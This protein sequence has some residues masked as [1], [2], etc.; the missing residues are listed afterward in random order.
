MKFVK[1]ISLFL[2]Y[3]AIMLVIGMYTGIVLDRFFYPGREVKEG[4]I[5]SAENTATPEVS[6]SPWHTSAL[7]DEETLENTVLV[8]DGEF[9]TDNVVVV[10]AAD[11]ILTADTEYII[12]EYDTRRDTLI[13]NSVSVPVKYLGMNREEFVAAM[14][15]YAISPPL[16]EQERGFVGLEVRSFSASRVVVRM[17]Y[18]YVEPTQSFFIKVEDNKIVVYC[19]DEETLYMYTNIEA[20]SLP[21]YIQTQVSVGM[22]VEDEES[23]Y[24]FLESYSS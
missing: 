11:E 15:L 12:E 1:G 19:D 5:Q 13:E 18:A 6:A 10:A 9:M 2:L 17:H 7:A 14:E 16:S 23:L 22:F 4:L 8:T 21:G 24:H 20:E 3:P